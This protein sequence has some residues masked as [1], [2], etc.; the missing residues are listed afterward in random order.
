[1]TRDATLQCMQVENMI[2]PEISAA[3]GAKRSPWFPVQHNSANQAPMRLFCFSFAG[4]GAASYHSWSSELSPHI[5]VCPILLP[6]RDGR[7]KEP[8][9]TD[10]G[11]ACEQ[12]SDAIVDFLD[13]P[14]LIYGHSLGALM[15]YQVVINLRSKGLKLPQHCFFSAHRSPDLPYP[16]PLTEQASDQDLIDWLI[17]HDGI[18]KQI[19]DNQDIL[20]FMLPRI[21][22]DLK[23]CESYHCQNIA[24][25]A[26]PIT[27]Y[28][29]KDD[30]MVTE[31]EMSGWKNQT[32]NLF[33]YQQVLG[34][35]LFLRSNA[36]PVLTDIHA[37]Y[38]A[39]Q[40]QNH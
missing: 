31:Q 3:S 17:Q 30:H 29:G 27:S 26:M 13:K 7:L 19:L 22:A 33:R 38:H 15:A 16:H 39:W 4:G 34:D 23:L 21:K 5:E 32:T 6:G 24:P 10:F 12:I 14:F 36:A 11:I 37:A 9:I 2:H 20:D 1:M 35:H 8:F 25:L 28:R 40:E 18:P